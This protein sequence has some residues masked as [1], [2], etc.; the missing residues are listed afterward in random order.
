MRL[1]RA[2]LEKAI[3]EAM[4]WK[5]PGMFKELIENGGLETEVKRRADQAEEDYE[6]ASS[7]EMTRILT[8][9][10]G[11]PERPYLEGVQ[12]LTEAQNRTWREALDQA[13]EFQ[14]EEDEE[15]EEYEDPYPLEDEEEI[16]AEL[17]IANRPEA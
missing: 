10:P 1:S 17:G 14:R 2:Q 9:R 11:E 5:A 3:I 6:Y 4:K 7:E 12:M 16:L 8:V 13:C 15:S